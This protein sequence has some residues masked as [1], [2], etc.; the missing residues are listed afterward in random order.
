M[1]RGNAL[2]A[3]LFAP[4]LLAAQTTQ[5][6]PAPAQPA[7]TGA[8]LLTFTEVSTDAQQR[9]IDPAKPG[10]VDINSRVNIAIDQAALAAAIPTALKLP[11]VSQQLIDRIHFVST[12]VS[13]REQSLQ[14][15]KQ[16]FSAALLSPPVT[17]AD[18][19]TYFDIVREAAK[20]AAQLINAPAAESAFFN[21]RRSFYYKTLSG[22]D[23]ANNALD[24]Y[25]VIFL[26][27]A[28][29]V[30][31][32][33]SDLNT[34]AAQNGVYV[35]LGAW[36]QDRPVHLEGF[37]TYPVGDHFVVERFNINLSDEQKAEL[38]N[39]AAVSK[40]L[41]AEDASAL[42]LWR[43]LGSTM[44]E[45]AVSTGPTAQCIRSLQQQ[46]EA[47]KTKI[48][49]STAA[50]QNEYFAAK[51]DVDTYIKSLD[52]LKTKYAAGGITGAVPADQ[53]LIGTNEDVTKLIGDT[54]SLIATLQKAESTMRSI[55]AQLQGDA[56]TSVTGLA[57]SAAACAQTAG[58][59]VES[60]RKS[61]L[62]SIHA[63]SSGSSFDRS[64]LDF[65]TDVTKLAAAD[66]PST[67]FIPLTYTGRRQRGDALTIK[68][69]AGTPTTS[70]VVLSEA[71]FVLYQT[72]PYIT[73]KVG[74]IFAN[75]RSTNTTDDAS[76]T[77]T[78][79]TSVRHF[80]TAPAYSVLLK[81]DSPT[82]MLWNTVI[83]PGVGINV[84]ALDFNHDDTPELG[85]GLVG[86]VFRDI[87]QVGYG[88]NVPLGK[89]YA[90]FGLRLP[91]PSYTVTGG[92]KTNAP[93]ANP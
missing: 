8:P 55:A 61:I 14:Q 2:C 5:P 45:N 31:Q 18:R 59:E 68:L 56:K 28:D 52:A 13:A 69:A 70:R 57:S 30:S 50:L 48:T 22:L 26:A 10:A 32:L 33:R 51:G 35:Q 60:W 87:V 76:G 72:L 38:A 92:A 77:S 9:T 88:Y 71:D 63:L 40:K 73:T 25:A 54:Q 66:V 78:T 41:N 43:E 44:I 17:V 4:A 6:V 19:N 91:L 11:N 23:P 12:A 15:L 46:F 85:V 36:V 64:V 89:W 82:R 75:P 81:K 49:G 93:P 67:T 24:Q 20:P 53:F 65:G 29:E 1:K 27:A 80:Q 3:L 79:Q 39:I 74:L 42:T 34:Y 62:G 90:F 58:S 83:D 86:S 84:S 37:D 21:Q 47:D 7:P 16:A